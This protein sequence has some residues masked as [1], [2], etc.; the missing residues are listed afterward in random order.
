M[1]F[2]CTK[3]EN[4]SYKVAARAINFCFECKG[5]SRRGTIEA[6]PVLPAFIFKSLLTWWN[7]RHDLKWLSY[8]FSGWE[9]KK[10]SIELRSRDGK[11]KFERRQTRNKWTRKVFGNFLSNCF[12]NDEF[13]IFR[14]FVQ[15]FMTFPVRCAYPN[16]FDR[17]SLAHSKC[18]L[19]IQ[20]T[21][22]A[23]KK[24]LFSR[25]IASD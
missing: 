5:V 19:L 14:R 21:F 2:N 12:R 15:V 22:G 25:T 16:L 23:R 3:V 1:T 4:A 24:T 6:D 11:K 17:V 7:S 13:V 18:F 9:K 20:N 8:G 10:I